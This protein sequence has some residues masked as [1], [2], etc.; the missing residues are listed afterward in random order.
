MALSVDVTLSLT[1]AAG[2]FMAKGDLEAVQRAHVL[3]A[4]GFGDIGE[5]VEPGRLPGAG[6]LVGKVP[7]G[8]HQRP[9]GKDLL[10][11]L[12]ECLVP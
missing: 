9:V 5:A 7:R 11:Q 6:H 12:V 8:L 10:L 1:R 2:M 3:A 4:Q